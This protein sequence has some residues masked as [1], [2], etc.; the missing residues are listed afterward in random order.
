MCAKI[1]VCTGNFYLYG[2]IKTMY[3]NQYGRG[4]RQFRFKQTIVFI[5]YRCNYVVERRN[6]GMYKLNLYRKITWLIVYEYVR[7]PCRKTE[8]SYYAY[9]VHLAFY[10]TIT[11]KKT[12]INPKTVFGPKGFVPAACNSFGRRWKITIL[13][14][15]F[16]TGVYRRALV[17]RVRSVAAK[18][19]KHL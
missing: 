5:A 18:P 6:F 10:A 1:L 8:R 13:K 7:R 11:G 15:S 17:R 16:I 14:I 19:Y 4:N 12:V 2:R 9:I 3:V